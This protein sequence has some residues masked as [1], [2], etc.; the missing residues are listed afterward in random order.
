M[1]LSARTT[2][3]TPFGQRTDN[4]NTVQQPQTA[5]NTN[6]NTHPQTTTPYTPTPIDSSTSLDSSST[7]PFSALSTSSATAAASLP[8]L[9]LPTN[10]LENGS[11]LFTHHAISTDTPASSATHNRFYYKLVAKVGPSRL[12]SIFDGVT[13]YV[14]GQTIRTTIHP[15]P[16]GAST[17]WTPRRL[18]DQIRGGIFVC[19]TPEEALQA[20]IPDHAALYCAPR[21]LIKVIAWGDKIDYGSTIA[22]THVRPV[23]V[24]PLSMSY[25]CTSF[26]A[27]T[28]T[29][30]KLNETRKRLPP[31]NGPKRV[32]PQTFRSE[33]NRN[34]DTK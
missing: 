17:T 31:F 23:Q 9:R 15:L 7:T 6:T 34:T 21:A 19:R 29:V 14:V 22:F 26:G 13:D 11:D 5:R 32:V 12:V 25:L 20:R 10:R 18:R 28:A 8:P 2:V 16:P 4:N 27:R 30:V 33:T 1:A 24:F 3:V